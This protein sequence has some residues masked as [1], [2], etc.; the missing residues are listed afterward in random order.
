MAYK[1]YFSGQTMTFETGVK[2]EVMCGTGRVYDAAGRCLVTVLPNMPAIVEEVQPPAAQ[3]GPPAS[4][5]GTRAG[6]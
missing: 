5:R 1:V 6:D 3:P 2:F 4:G